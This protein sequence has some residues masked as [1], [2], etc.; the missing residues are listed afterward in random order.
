MVENESLANASIA[1][2]KVKSKLH[3]SRTGKLW[4][5]FMHQV[6]LLKKFIKA[7]RTGNWKLHL[8]TLQEM[9]PYFAATGHNLYTKT[10]SVYLSQMQSLETDHPDVF[11]H[12]QDG[13][14]VLRRSDKCWA[15]LSTDLIIEQVNTHTYMYMVKIYCAEE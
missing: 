14:H 11:K 5:V 10:V 2:E 8:S 13:H 6:D 12:F 3:L 4:L 7:E 1:V 9:M 15:G